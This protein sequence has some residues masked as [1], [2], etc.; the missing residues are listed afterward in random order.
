MNADFVNETGDTI[1]VKKRRLPGACDTCRRKKIK[2]DSA[3]KPD[4]VCTN[5]A[6]YGLRCRHEEPIKKRGPKIG[7]SYVQELEQ[8]VNSLESLLHELKPDAL[9]RNPDSELSTMYNKVASPTSPVQDT[10][11]TISQSRGLTPLL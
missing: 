7:G 8:R 11:S 6:Q 10:W 1:T 4:G 5:C 9:S 2:C 3:M